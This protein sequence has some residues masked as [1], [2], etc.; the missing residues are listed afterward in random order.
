MKNVIIKREKSDD[1]QT[2]GRMYYDGKQVAVTLELP[3]KGNSNRI[4]CIPKGNYKVIRRSSPK[5]G[6]HFHILDVP[7]RSYILIHNA[8]YYSDLL[9]CIGVGANFAFINKDA[10]L[11][12]TSSRAT[13]T[14]LLKILP[15]EFEL[16]I[17]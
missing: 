5:Y 11:D 12:I 15:L 9:G 3:W 4:S 8:N 2:L 13:M 10:H 6:N 16:T 17:E 7:G 1:V 14:Q